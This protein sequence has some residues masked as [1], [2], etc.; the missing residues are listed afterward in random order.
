MKEVIF[1]KKTFNS[2]KDFYIQI[3]KDLDG[4]NTIDWEDYKDLGY[5]G[6]LLNEFLWYKQDEN[7]K[8]I[9][10]NFNKEKI[11]LQKNFDDYQYNIITTNLS[12]EWKM[13]KNKNIE[14]LRKMRRS[15][16]TLLG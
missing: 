14:V 2:Y 6:N 3:Y 16:I 15:Q 10:V 13:R 11:K 9:F 4:A 7:I 1:D 5:N 8:Y 12:L